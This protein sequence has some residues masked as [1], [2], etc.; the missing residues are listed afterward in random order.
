MRL[1]VTL[2]A[3]TA[4][5][6]LKVSGAYA[7]D[8][9]GNQ[10][11]SP[12]APPLDAQNKGRPAVSAGRGPAHRI[13]QPGDGK[14]RS[15]WAVRRGISANDLLDSWRA[16]FVTPGAHLSERATQI[17]NPVVSKSRVG[18]ALSYQGTCTCGLR[19]KST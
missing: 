12:V 2:L 9:A 3:T 8:N 17:R 15:P 16:E 19:S 5:L 13:P 6:F 1:N 14:L 4:F 7:A 10:A 11:A 18:M